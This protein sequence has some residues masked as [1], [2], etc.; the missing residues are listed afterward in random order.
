MMDI[1]YTPYI[2]P[3][4]EFL[5]ERIHPPRVSVDN[6]I[7]PDCSLIMVDSANKH[8]V[9]LEMV[10]VLTD[11]DLLISK[12]YIS[13]D[14]GWLM[15]VFHVTDQQGYKLTDQNL[16]HQIQE[17]IC[18]SRLP[19]KEA[20]PRGVS[21]DHVAFEMTGLDRPGLMSEM[22]AVLAEMDC[23][24]SA[25]VAWTHKGRAA[26]IIYVEDTSGN[27][28]RMADP[29][30]AAQVRS[31]LENV[32]EAHHHEDERHSV[33]LASPS[34]PHGEA[35]PPADGR[36]PRLRPM[37]LVLQRKQRMGR[38]QCV[39]WM[40]EGAEEGADWD[41]C[42]DTEVQ[43]NRLLDCYRSTAFQE[44]YITD[45]NGTLETDSEKHRVTKCLVAATERRV[46]HV[47]IETKNLHQEPDGTAI[48][49]YKCS[50]GERAINNRAEIGTRGE[51][52][53]G[54]FYLKD[55]TGEDVSPETVEVVRREIGGRTV[56]ENVSPGTS[57]ESTPS[58]TSSGEEERTSF[59]L[60]GLI[61]SQLEWLSGNFKPT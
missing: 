44:Y 1:T 16:I 5:L 55:A 15:D 60:R 23:H 38:H 34:P 45:K 26:C 32:V 30:R 10:Q 51:N 8:G 6:D 21:A 46:S 56:F 31:H 49:R 43:G 4:F 3:D 52:A 22:S 14:G 11:L 17:A 41:S 48:G 47:W 29:A 18:K 59:S 20:R 2:D 50:S 35:P 33:T 37:L 36:G 24:I 9:L 57:P 12:S 39:W 7:Y 42:E 27:A 54:T 13:S 28:G 40:P 25:A 58:R 61:W 19:N 53:V